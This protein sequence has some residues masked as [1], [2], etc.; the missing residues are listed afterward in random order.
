MAGGHTFSKS[1]RLPAF[2]LYVCE[3]AILGRINEVTEQQ[4]GIHVFGRAP[5]YNYSED[6]IV[7]THAR[8]LRR[9]IE[10][11]YAAEGSH[12]N[13]RILIPKGGYLPVFETAPIAEPP[14][15]PPLVP[16]PGSPSP[17]FERP[18]RYYRLIAAG[19]LLMVLVA[20]AGYRWLAPP[21][22]TLLVRQF[23][24]Q[25]FNPG[26]N[27]V[28]V[29]SDTAFVL[30]QNYSHRTVSLAEYLSRDFWQTFDPPPNVNPAWISSLRGLPYTNNIDLGLCWRLAR[31]PA[32]DLNRTLV[33]PSR[34]LQ[35]A[36]LK[37]SNAIII[38]ARRGNPWVELFDEKNNFQGLFNTELSNHIVN[39]APRPTE[40]P[41]YRAGPVNGVTRSY[42][43]IEYTRGLS[44][45]EH[46]LIL[47]GLTGPSTEGAGDFLLNDL[48]FG[49]FLDTLTPPRQDVPHF[50]L[51]LAVD[52]INASAPRTEVVA[53]RLRPE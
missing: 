36:D 33:R 49:R 41:V 42:A 34:D 20:F 39:H 6:N 14:P 18:P 3:R 35:M 30:F 50:E 11:Y 27:T 17:S 4:V 25:V 9:K 52:L 21:R 12:E 5:D 53:Y 38:G 24:S 8:L 43:L 1:A 15:V 32:L 47:S 29:P 28:L 23:W 45:G 22:P 51:L 16:P 26:Q 10:E 2:L 37:G 44:P 13:L 19:V 46:V 40:H 7:R 31:K 48:A